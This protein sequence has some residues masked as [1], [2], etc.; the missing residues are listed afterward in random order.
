MIFFSPFQEG[1]AETTVYMV[2]GYGLI[3]IVMAFYIASL[4]LRWKNLERDRGTLE[5]MLP[6]EPNSREGLEE[7]RNA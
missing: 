6:K 2:A 7:E 3:L 1:P 4:W 5:S